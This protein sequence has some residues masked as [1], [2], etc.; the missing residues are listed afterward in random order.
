MDP[1]VKAVGEPTRLRICADLQRHRGEQRMVDL[2]HRL[3]PRHHYQVRHH[4]RMLAD[5]G[6]VR[7]R[8][9]VDGMHVE[10]LIELTAAGKAALRQWRDELQEVVAG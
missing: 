2:I 9:A 1:L 5:A 10:T 3:N 6:V 8:K 7:V 4:A